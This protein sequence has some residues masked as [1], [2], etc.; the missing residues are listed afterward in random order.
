[1][2]KFSKCERWDGSR[3][4]IFFDPQEVEHTN[5]DGSSVKLEQ[6]AKSIIVP[7]VNKG[8]VVSALIREKYSVNDELALLRQKTSKKAEFAAYDTF[9]EESKALADSILEALNG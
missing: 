3:F 1:M 4:I 5:P 6:Y 7:E 2:L 8:E 9:A